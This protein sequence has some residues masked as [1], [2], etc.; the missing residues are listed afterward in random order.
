M[1]KTYKNLEEFLLAMREAFGEQIR[2][3]K[4]LEQKMTILRLDLRSKQCARCE[5]TGKITMKVP[6][7]HQPLDTLSGDFDIFAE[8][9]TKDCQLCGGTGKNG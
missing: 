4:E 9:Q 2:A 6:K 3:E 7:T 8:D 5:G 1:P